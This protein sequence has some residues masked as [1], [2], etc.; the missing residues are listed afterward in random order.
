M[1]NKSNVNVPI[2]ILVIFAGIVFCLYINRGR[3][4][5]T[6]TTTESPPTTSLSPTLPVI[7]QAVAIEDTTCYFGTN[8][9]YDAFVPIHQFSIVSVLGKDLSG[10]WLLVRLEGFADCWIQSKSLQPQDSGN[11][12][13][14]TSS[15]PPVRT[16]VP[17]TA[18][19]STAV[20]TITTQLANQ[21][22][23]PPIT[24]TW[25][26]L[27]FECN[28]NGRATRA[29]VNL[30]VSG[31]VPPYK[32]SPPLPE[33]VKPEQVVSLQVSS[34]TSNGEPSNII[35]FPIPRASDFKCDREGD[36]QVPPPPTSPPPTKPSFTSPPTVKPSP[37]PACSDGQDNEFP[38][39]GYTDFPA[40]PQ[41][42]SLNDSH[43]DQ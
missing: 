3:I 27:S 2:I 19:A 42:D 1:I 30:N 6:P 16:Q 17:S 34:N 4:I 25:S 22:P 9:G 5:P 35:S 12:P 40:D 14:I 32:Y 41:C 18:V 13:V 20:A 11:L 38:P 33:F 24:Y 15:L 28:S 10:E 39:D 37:P 23:Y 7:Y 8:Q 29:K 36:N 21:T 26:I 31:G 43:E